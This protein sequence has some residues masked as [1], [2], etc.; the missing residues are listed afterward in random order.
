MRTLENYNIC[1]LDFSGKIRRNERKTI[2]A[3]ILVEIFQ[4]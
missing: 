3:D 1:V 2:F 4:T